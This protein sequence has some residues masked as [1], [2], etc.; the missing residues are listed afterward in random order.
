[1]RSEFTIKKHMDEIGN[2]SDEDASRLFDIIQQKIMESGNLYK[3]P[4]GIDGIVTLVQKKEF[5]REKLI[6]FIKAL[7][8]KQV[9]IW[10]KQGWNKAIPK[11]YKEYDVLHSYLNTL[12]NKTLIK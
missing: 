2:L 10:I 5:L 9:G 6:Q 12:D 3:K 1:M 4:R 7:P 8:K 11:D